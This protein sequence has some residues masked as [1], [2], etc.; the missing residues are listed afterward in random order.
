MEHR[1]CTE[2]DVLGRGARE[3]RDTLR[4]VSERSRY[5]LLPGCRTAG[6][7][8]LHLV[9]S[10]GIGGKERQAVELIKGLTRWTDLD[11]SVV[12]MDRADFYLG[13]VER[14]AVRAERLA[15]RRRWDVG[16]FGRVFRVV[17]R[18]KPAV[19]HTNGLVSTFYA[20]PVARLLGPKVVNGSIRNAFSKGGMRWKL[21]RALLRL[22]DFRV[23]NSDAGL[24]SRGLHQDGKRNFVVHNGFDRGRIGGLRGDTSKSVAAVEPPPPGKSV[25]GMVAE[26]SAYKD[27]RTYVLAALDLLRRRQDVVFWAIGGGE[28]LEET[29]ALVPGG[30]AGIRFLG[31]RKDVEALG[32]SFSVGVLATH[33]EGISNSIMEYMAMGKPVVATD[34]GGTRELVKHGETGYLVPPAR[35]D[36]LAASLEK[37][38]DEPATAAAM[39][40]AGR[41]RIERE[42]SLERMTQKTVSIYRRAAG[43]WR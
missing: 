14:L 42:F 15:R 1:S 37:L 23:A 22:S 9:D 3:E 34:G 25:V 8:V 24:R 7:R 32:R 28:K 4:A 17:R 12:Y 5:P 33:T 6:L 29:R 30:C 26:F 41:R 36:L 18:C 10:L 35:P 11:L 40:A 31:V 27:Y 38:L 19:I 2:P 20:L 21:E 16:L 13:D 43:A 39:G